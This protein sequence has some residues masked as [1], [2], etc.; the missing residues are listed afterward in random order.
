MAETL[1]SLRFAERAKKITNKAEVNR[2]GVSP[3]VLQL[4]QAN[5]K[6][7]AQLEHANNTLKEHGLNVTDASSSK[8]GNFK[9][10][11]SSNNV[12][13]KKM[14]SLKEE[15]EMLK[16]ENETIQLQ[17][18]G[19][20]NQLQSTTIELESLQSILGIDVHP[21]SFSTKT[22]GD[23][24]QN[25]ALEN[26]NAKTKISGKSLSSSTA[27]GKDVLQN[28]KTK[29]DNYDAMI[30]QL[31]ET[32]VCQSPIGEMGHSNVHSIEQKDNNNQDEKKDENENSSNQTPFEYLTYIL[33]QQK[34]V[35]TSMSSLSLGG[36]MDDDGFNWGSSSSS[37]SSEED[38][39]EGF[40]GEDDK[41][42]ATTTRSNNTSSLTKS[43][44]EKKKEQKKERKER[45]K[46][47]Q[48][49]SKIKSS[50]TIMHKVTQLKSKAKKWKLKLTQ[51]K[52]SHK[53]QKKKEQ[54]HL[55]VVQHFKQT[56]STMQMTLT[57][58]SQTNVLQV[59]KLKKFTSENTT[60][61]NQL[62][63]KQQETTT[64][65]EIQELNVEHFKKE[66]VTLQQQHVSRIQD[67]NHQHE[68]QVK[69]LQQQ[70]LCFI[71][72]QKLND[73]KVKEKNT[74]TEKKFQ[75]K[76]EQ[77]HELEK[78]ERELKKKVADSISTIE[79]MESE[80]NKKSQ[81]VTQLN[82]EV[83]DVETSHV[84]G[85]QTKKQNYFYIFVFFFLISFS[86][87]FFFFLLQVSNKLKLEIEQLNQSTTN[88]SK[89][90]SDSE[91]ALTRQT[92][93]RAHV[94]EDHATF[95]TQHNKVV[96]QHGTFKI[97][98]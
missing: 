49:N 42:M 53:E 56:T 73:E 2:D 61:Q 35:E 64:L 68:I 29:A 65:L 26:K 77:I 97:E 24:R 67:L 13:F 92:T 62:S 96:Q 11:K 25:V 79:T 6:L 21:T 23:T 88:L 38:E 98:K 80:L 12:D 82:K 60:L 27:N 87:F 43:S 39:E 78:K 10:S 18:N 22:N 83:K 70:H 45:K 40:D 76:N 5:A 41:E 50:H 17:S 1:D 19:I 90:L 54:Q 4:M 84:Q 7:K 85:K 20:R 47:K 94:E 58:K 74:K 59:E 15:V 3:Q 93:L 72:E 46:K 75:N 57:E 36:E 91:M 69:T 37:S 55:E 48:K 86:Y 81:T 31:L 9:K 71:Q 16:K 95:Q 44:K 63:K 32:T 66:K 52:V 28:L 34:D 30:Q 8:N 89:Q 14:E 33:K 51:L